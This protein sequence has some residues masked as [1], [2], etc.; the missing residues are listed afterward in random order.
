VK[1]ALYARVSKSEEGVQHIEN[2]LVPLRKMA[3]A[4]GYEVYKE[5]VDKVTGSTSDR[6]AFKQMLN[7]AFEVKFHI[8]FVWSLDRFSREGI[9]Q[10]MNYIQRLRDNNIPLKSLQEGWLDTREEGLAELMLAIFAWVAKQEK[11]KIS[12]RTKE[13]LAR[14]R[15]QGKKLGRPK[16]S[17]DR[18]P[19]RRKGYFK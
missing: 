4:L 12:N 2:Q 8:V 5:Y 15:R 19:R 3:D 1:A 17:K 16:G 10:T 11:V 7:D 18:K 9:L 13:G 6:P 14:A